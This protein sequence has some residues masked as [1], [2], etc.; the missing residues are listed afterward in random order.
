MQEK[1]KRSLKFRMLIMVTSLILVVFIMI[2]CSLR[3]LSHYIENNAND[4]LSE[5]R[6]FISEIHDNGSKLMIIR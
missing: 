4:V 3:S 1:K 2:I 6:Q 5:S